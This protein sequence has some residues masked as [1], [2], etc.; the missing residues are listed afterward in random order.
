M[1]VFRLL[2]FAAVAL[3]PNSAIADFLGVRLGV[4][5]WQSQAGGD[6]GRDGAD[7]AG[8]LRLGGSDHNYYALSF[9]HPLPGL[10]N[11]RLSKVDMSVGADAVLVRDVRF[12]EVQFAAGEQIQTALD[13]SHTD[14][15]LYYEFLDNLVSADLGMTL[16]QFDGRAAITGEF[17]DEVLEL[18]TLV[19]L[20]Y[21][22]ARV[23]LPFTGL[24]AAID[25]NFMNV[26]QL[27]LVDWSAQLQYNWEM[28]PA[29]NAGVILGYRKMVL[30]LDDFDDLHADSH[31]DGFYLALELHI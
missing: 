8:E 23:D 26:D 2:G 16:R 3:L 14:L 29:V 13:L 7:L 20:A 22:R 17:Q 18:D 10:P 25:G 30:E 19:P 12:E 31:F 28:L 9:E 24:A 1:K 5:Q 4:G 15:T 27:Q 6:L 11:L 21:G